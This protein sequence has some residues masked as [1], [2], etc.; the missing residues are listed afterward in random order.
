MAV[1]AEGMVIAAAKQA[2]ELAAAGAETGNLA[3]G[4]KP[5]HAWEVETSD[6]A[7]AYASGFTCEFPCSLPCVVGTDERRP[8]QVPANAP[9]LIAVWPGPCTPRI[10]CKNG[11]GPLRFTHGTGR[12]QSR[13]SCW[14]PTG[15]HPANRHSDSGR[16]WCEADGQG[17]DRKTIRD[18]A[19]AQ[20]RGTAGRK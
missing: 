14:F 20:I 4:E 3:A 19:L 1:L 16:R 13:S 17:N 5:W 15:L 2:A 10:N 12:K 8:V 18:A 7:L 9:F 6:P 11:C